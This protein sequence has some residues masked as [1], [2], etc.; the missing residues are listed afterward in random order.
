MDMNYE[1]YIKFVLKQITR[2][3]YD[4]P[5]CCTVDLQIIREMQ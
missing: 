5:V 4:H 2:H 3:V 1:E